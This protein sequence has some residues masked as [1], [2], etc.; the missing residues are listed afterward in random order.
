MTIFKAKLIVVVAAFAA[1]QGCVGMIM[2][3]GEVAVPYK[4]TEVTY[5]PAK[6]STFA[7][8]NASPQDL[9]STES[10]TFKV[11]ALLGFPSMKTFPFA[12]F[13][14]ALADTSSAQSVASYLAGNDPARGEGGKAQASDFFVSAGLAG[15]ISPV[16]AVAGVV[17]SDRSWETGDPR[18]A[19]STVL[20]FKPVTDFDPAG[21]LASCYK[22][23]DAHIGSA[24]TMREP[25]YEFA[26]HLMYKVNLPLSNGKTAINDIAVA[27]YGAGYAEGYA[28]V[29]RGGFKAHMI[30]MRLLTI[31]DRSDKA[32]HYRAEE[33]VA[34]LSKGKPD[35]LVYLISP[36]ADQ[37]ARKD[38]EPFGI[39]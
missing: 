27:R 25:Q 38:I 2:R 23:V 37:Q 15:D 33:L 22:D 13:N 36:A 18:V 39:Y 28:P 5:L 26:R 1:L 17:A 10:E 8:A 31:Y 6:H 9:D 20:C 32:V 4:D 11:L 19:Y 12:K 3:P 7:Y 24:F 16:G 30:K 34:A 21:A 35:S 29:D 14:N